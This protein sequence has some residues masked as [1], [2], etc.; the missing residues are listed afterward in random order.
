LGPARP[1]RLLGHLG[2]QAFQR[3][4]VPAAQRH[5]GTVGRDR[6]QPGAE[7]GPV[8]QPRQPQ[9]GGRGGFLGDVLGLGAWAEQP[10]AQPQHARLPARQQRVERL[11]VAGQD[12]RDQFGIVALLRRVHHVRSVAPGRSKVTPARPAKPYSAWTLSKRGVGEWNRE[13]GPKPSVAAGDHGDAQATPGC[14]PASTPQLLPDQLPAADP[15]A[16]GSRE[17]ARHL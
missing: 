6:L 15:V 14:D 17:P 3:E 9:K 2:S 1:A 8:G 4:P 13:S 16:P 5:A 11:A 7:P 10:P 12:R